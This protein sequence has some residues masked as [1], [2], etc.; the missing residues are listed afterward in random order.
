MSRV[1]V[2]IAPG[3]YVQGA[4]A[5]AEIGEHVSRLG[6]K[7]FVTGGRAIGQAYLRRHGI[8]AE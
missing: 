3:R 2:M 7:V 8:T 4:G 1:K 6:K 5:L